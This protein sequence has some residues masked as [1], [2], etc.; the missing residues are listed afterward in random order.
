VGIV[1]VT[2]GFLGGV[3]GLVRLA[4][5]VVTPRTSEPTVAPGPLAPAWSASTGDG[6]IGGVVVGDGVVY[7]GGPDGLLAYPDPCPA[8]D[9]ACR[10][11]WHDVIPDGPLST[12]I[13]LGD[14]V[15]AG[16]AGGRLYG[17][18]ATCAAADCPPLWS[19]AAGPGG[20]AAPAANADLVYVASDRLYAFPAR[21]G[22][23]DRVCAPAWTAP[24]GGHAAAGPPAVGGGLVVVASG[25]PQGGIDAFPAVCAGR[26]R[27]VWHGETGGAATAVALTSDTAF[28]VARGA[29][30]AFPMSC[31]EVCVPAWSG[32]LGSGIAADPGA[33][34]APAVEGDEVYV[35]TSDGHLWVFPDACEQRTC[36]PVR[37]YVLGQMPLGTPAVEGGTIFV[38]STGGTVFAISEPCD[39]PDAPDACGAGWSET[40]G[41]GIPG[42]PVAT[43]RT[44]YVGDAR[45]VLH[46]YTIRG[47]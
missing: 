18:S 10:P 4:E 44:M 31:P 46:A 19:G 25:S 3:G 28:V 22:T 11:L 1:A 14:V 7:V 29:L 47:A 33:V 39:A 43:E 38:S 6:P 27:P 15:V 12:P 45:G 36:Q 2:V 24:I 21:C 26:C 13:T 32:P 42:A 35:S 8:P 17:F 16:S 40:L 41:A 5:G 9:G 30:M 37:G 34:S 23:D 20:A